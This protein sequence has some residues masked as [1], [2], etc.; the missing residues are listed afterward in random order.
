MK[1]D[2]VYLFAYGTLLEPDVQQRVFGY[3]PAGSEDALPAYRKQD[4]A[5]GGK[6]PVV[7]PF[8]ENTEGVPGRCL[9][10]SRADLSRADQY[11]TR[12]YRRELLP[13]ASGRKAWVYLGNL[14]TPGT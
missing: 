9:E 10:I 7:I 1:A 5:I 6:Y 8:P 4:A 11:E 13:L 2:R 14:K 12:L 3:L